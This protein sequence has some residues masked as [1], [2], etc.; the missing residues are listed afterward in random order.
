MKNCRH[1][2]KAYILTNLKTEETGECDACW[3]FRMMLTKA[4]ELAVK[5]ILSDPK[6]MAFVISGMK[7]GLKKKPTKNPIVIVE[8]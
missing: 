3:C 8:S 1:C 7:D 4:P 6:L 5:I 2:N